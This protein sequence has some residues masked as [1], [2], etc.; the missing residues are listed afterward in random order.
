[1]YN[2]II[3]LSVLVICIFCSFII[4]VDASDYSINDLIEK[5][6]EFN[7]K[8]IAVTGEAIGEP[9][10]RG[11]NTWVNINDKSNAMGV[12]MNTE[13]SNKITTYGGFNKIGDV[14]KVT[15][16][17]NRACSEHGGDMDIHALGID[18][19][20]KGTKL[21]DKVPVYKI[22]LCIV[23]TITTG[24]LGLILYKIFNKSND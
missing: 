17:F 1:M 16:V 19:L 18:I 24:I 12:Y 2:K 10:K 21:E 5:G 9:L 22:A 15:G 23:L 6:K 11:E 13:Y 8:N 3:R 7:G 14:I 20:D 4:Q